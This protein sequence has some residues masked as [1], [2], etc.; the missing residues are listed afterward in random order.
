[1]RHPVRGQRT[2]ELVLDRIASLPSSGDLRQFVRGVIFT[3]RTA[4]EIVAFRWA[5]EHPSQDTLS[6][7]L[8]MSPFRTLDAK[9]YAR[10]LDAHYRPDRCVAVLDALA[11][12]VDRRAG[13]AGGGLWHL[14]APQ[15]L[16]DA[17]HADGAVGA[18]QLAL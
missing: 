7:L 3:G 10:A 18:W 15:H 5:L 14:H 6:V 2:A 12:G 16:A 8:E 9:E 13:G 11:G 4:L 1:M 17:C